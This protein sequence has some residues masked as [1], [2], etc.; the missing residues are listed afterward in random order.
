MSS[1]SASAP[2]YNGGSRQQGSSHRRRGMVS[3][4][5]IANRAGVSI[6]TVSLVLNGKTENRVSQKTSEKVLQIAKELNY[7]PNAAAKTLKMRKSN[8]IGFLTDSIGSSPYAGTVL[9]GAQD[10]ARKLGYV[11]LMVNTNG[12]KQLEKQALSVMRGYQPD[13][14]IYALMYHQ[15]VTVPSQL[16]GIP[17]VVVD[18]EDQRGLVPSYFPDEFSIGYDA[19]TRLAQAGCQRIAYIGSPQ[20]IVAEINRYEGYRQ[21]LADAGLEFDDQLV[22]HYEI[23]ELGENEAAAARHLISTVQPDGIFCFNDQRAAVVYDAA[24][25]LGLAIGRDISIVGVDNE[26]IIASLL[27]P[28]LTTVELPHYAMGYQGVLRLVAQMDGVEAL[29]P[30]EASDPYAAT[31]LK[32]MDMQ[33]VSLR[34]EL[35]EKESVA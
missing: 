22:V 8:T 3:M 12:D 32:Q 30:L 2:T 15:K 27:I 26:A 23:D 21:A 1:T 33:A 13:G 16:E 6:G 14:Y 18:G 19:T 17:T 9:L 10:A 7:E 24:R 5:D 25:E 11:L 20:G 29:R 28:R 4:K 34:C 35:L 31:V